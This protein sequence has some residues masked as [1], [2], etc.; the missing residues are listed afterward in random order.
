MVQGLDRLLREIGR[1]GRNRVRWLAIGNEVDSY[2]KSRG[3]EIEPYA[4]MLDGV[5]S[6]I[7]SGFPDAQFTVNF[8]RDAA[9]DLDRKYRPLSDRGDFVS[10]TYYPLNFNFTMKAPSSADGDIKAMVDAAGSRQMLLQEV[11]YAS[12]ERLKSSEEKQAE[13]YRNVFAALERHQGRIIAANFLFM[14]DLPESTV[15]ELGNYYRLPLFKGN[16]KAYL[17][18]LGLFD[19]EGRPKP[20]WDVFRQSATRLSRG[21]EARE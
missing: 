21:R 14:S 5:R 16:F 1:R 11:G 4:R 18:T 7:T 15:E 10:F 17:A 6:T 12:S 20:A 8:T 19:R 13:F 9:S 2:F 3:R